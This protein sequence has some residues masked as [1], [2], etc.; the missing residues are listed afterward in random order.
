MAAKDPQKWEHL[1]GVYEADLNT[2]T[3]IGLISFF[4]SVAYD[5]RG[6]NIMLK[7]CFLSTATG[8]KVFS[9]HTWIRN[10]STSQVTKGEK[11]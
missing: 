11:V 8:K 3:V 5:Y 10:S 4:W 2:T 6:I 9:W 1:T 7:D